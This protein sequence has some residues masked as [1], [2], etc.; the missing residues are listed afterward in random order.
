[1]AYV[2][3]VQE[4]YRRNSQSR[5]ETANGP[6]PDALRAAQSAVSA[7]AYADEDCLAHAIQHLDM[8]GQRAAWLLARAVRAYKPN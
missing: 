7:L 6:S 5:P 8:G 4:W 1:M 3:T 2:S